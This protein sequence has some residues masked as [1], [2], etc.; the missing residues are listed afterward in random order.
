MVELRS[1]TVYQFKYGNKK[2][3]RNP[4]LIIQQQS[5]LKADCSP[6]EI[7][8][9]LHRQRKIVS[10]ISM[11]RLDVC[12]ESILSTF[13]QVMV[14]NYRIQV[15]LISRKFQFLS[16]KIGPHLQQ[17]FLMKK[18]LSFLNSK[19]FFILIFMLMYLDF[20]LGI[21]IHVHIQ[22]VQVYQV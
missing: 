2:I 9:F 5:T 1:V 13:S 21:R 15:L 3:R 8:F 4:F 14:P 7:N 10:F 6:E 22:Q 16:S 18:I 19:F 17:K 20:N 12:G 11:K